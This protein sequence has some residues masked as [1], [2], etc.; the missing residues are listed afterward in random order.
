M[1]NHEILLITRL[2]TLNKGNQALSAAWLS[3]LQRAFPSA[4]VRVLERRPP[5]L[6]QYTLRAVASAKDPVAAFDALS[7]R[8]AAQAPGPAA[9]TSVRPTTAIQLDESRPPV[10]RFVALRRRLN[11]RGRLAAVGWYADD[12]RQR[13]AA[14]QRARL[15]VVNPAGEFFP[16]EPLA[17]FYHL[18]DAHVAQKL[19]R[20]TAIVNHTM[21]ITDPTLRRLIP[22][23]Y[24]TL[25]L[26]GFRDTKSVEAF[27]A[28]GGSIDNVLVT[29]D[30]ALTTLITDSA[31]RRTREV[32]VAINVPEARAGG[33]LGRWR[34]AIANI[35]AAGHRIVLVSNELP[36]DEPF[37][38]ELKQ[39]FPELRI[40]GAAL[41]HDRYGALLGA[42][43]V[44]VTSR[45]HTAVLAMAAG[46]PVVP[47]EGSSFKITGLFQELGF[48]EPVIVP[49][50]ADWPASVVARVAEL[51]ASRASA[52][53]EVSAR[54]TEIRERIHEQLIPR[55]QTAAQRKP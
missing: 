15:V 14:C 27:R 50:S 7:T 49:T 47:I 35:R 46:A 43:E 17:A 30:L 6:L 55:L 23:V 11:L 1:Q 53:A 39:Q 41:D 20:P 19:G 54:M 21:D 51:H 5:H 48:S 52:S 9:A 37:Y 38:L 31:P 44:V 29:P 4:A 24:R 40:E 26:V 3:T 22:E 36:A 32:A 28:M 45:M 18:L 42:F 25:A 34:T 33:Y 12:Y 13:L 16:R 10:V 8:L 2:R